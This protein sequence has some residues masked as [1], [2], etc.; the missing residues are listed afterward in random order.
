MTRPG[1][2]TSISR[3]NQTFEMGSPM[4]LRFPCS[5]LALSSSGVLHPYW[6]GGVMFS[7]ACTAYVVVAHQV[8][9]VFVSID[10][11]SDYVLFAAAVAQRLGLS[12]PFTRQAAFS[13]AAGTQAG[14]LSFPPDGLVSLFVTD[15]TEYCY[16]PAPLIA[17]HPPTPQRQM[18]RSVL[19]LTGFL[20]YFRFVLDY[21]PAPPGFELHPIPGFPGR[22]GLLPK[23]RLLVDFIRG[24]RAP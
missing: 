20:Q 4:P 2:S 18:Q 11:R 6:T 5:R 7:P 21:S 23:D 19:G 14:I 12:L 16:L 9:R 15:Y 13:G 22:S 17:F 10:S 24:L 3:S 1:T 8:E